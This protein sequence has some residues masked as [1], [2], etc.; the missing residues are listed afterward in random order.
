MVNNC[1]SP[2]K[3]RTQKKL[4]S[5]LQGRQ[6]CHSMMVVWL[7]T[8]VWD[9]EGLLILISSWNRLEAHLNTHPSYSFDF[10]FWFFWFVFTVSLFSL[11]CSQSPSVRTLSSIRSCGQKAGLK[12]AVCSESFGCQ[13]IPGTPHPP[14][15]FCSL[16]HRHTWLWPVLHG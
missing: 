11:S 3:E 4:V 2:I 9:A 5:C 6:C 10:C 16:F 14:C 13:R 12:S 7:S 1:E 15:H 8:E